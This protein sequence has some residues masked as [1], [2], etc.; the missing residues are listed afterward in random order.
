MDFLDYLIPIGASITAIG[1][2]VVAI[3]YARAKAKT[4]PTIITIENTLL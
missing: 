3:F 1:V 4:Q 2:V